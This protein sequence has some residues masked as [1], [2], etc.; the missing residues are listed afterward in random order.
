MEGA[1]TNLL[2]PRPVVEMPEDAK[3]FQQARRHRPPT[4]RPRENSCA[5]T[6]NS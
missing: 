4:E 2:L 1:A 3:L 6:S 5:M